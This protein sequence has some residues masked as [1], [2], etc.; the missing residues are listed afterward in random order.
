M[1]L[2]C[3]LDNTNIFVKSIFTTNLYYF[4]DSQFNPRTGLIIG[5]VAIVALVIIGRLMQLQIFEDK[6]IIWAN[7]QSIYRKV[8]YPSRGTIVDRNG[9]TLMY[10]DVIYDLFADPSKITDDFDTAYFCSILEISTEEFTKKLQTI[11]EKNGRGKS[12]MFLNQLPLAQNA[13][14]QEELF[15]FPGFEMVERSSRKYP[16]PIGALIFGYISEITPT[17][18][19]QEKYASYRQGD[20]VG[21]T[22]LENVYEER[23]RGTRGVQYLVRDV[24]NRPRESFQNGELD[25]PAVAGSTLELYLDADLQELTEKLMQNKIGSA[26]AIDPKTGGILAFVSAPTFDPNLLSG[27]E[28]SKNFSKLYQ[29]PLTPL[30]NRGISGS[31][32]PGSTF[33]PITAMV[34]LDDGV[35]TPSYGYPCGGGYYACGRRIGC[36][37]SGGG[38][39]ANLRAAMANSCNAYFC[40]VF[41]MVTDNKKHGGFRDGYKVWEEYMHKFG[42]GHKLGI[43]ITGE[44]PGFIA[45]LDFYDKRNGGSNYSSCNMTST[46]MGQ[47]ALELTPLQLAN[48]MCII[49]NKG[50]YYTPH[51]VKSIDGDEN[52]PELQKY[53]VKNEAVTHIPSAYFDAVIDGMEEVVKGGTGRVAQLPGIKVCGKTGTVENYAIVHGRYTKLDNHSVFVCFAPKEDPKIAIAVIVENSGY[54][55]T[56]AGPVATLM[57]EQY[58][59]GEVKRPHLINKLEN[60]RLVKSYVYYL[61]SVRREKDKIR[62]LSQN[63]DKRFVDSMKKLL[64]T[65][66]VRESFM[67]MNV[68]IRREEQTINE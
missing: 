40:H 14:L 41:R 62:Y 13:R 48:A 63:Q 44:S 56:W 18:L 21:L 8:V 34:G 59:T 7:D 42:L 46:G 47:D 60:S 3:H 38:H 20:Y 24:M 19:Q 12:G 61:D 28:R 37:H 52:A 1:K 9:N 36:T 27:P 65:T 15:M 57:M 2:S 30:F 29:D 54:G 58:L 43:D 64:D 35:I 66:F 45:G 39:S 68:P 25:T 17:M 22:G 11:I 4:M 23:L 53:R 33:K 31:Y 10:N 6:Y 32:P 5:I 51:F 67:K 16:R 49:A 50:Y 55:A 26:I